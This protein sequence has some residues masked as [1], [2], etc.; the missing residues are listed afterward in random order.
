MVQSQGVQQRRMQVVR[1]NLVFDRLDAKLV[2]LPVPQA[3]FHASSSEPHGIGSAV[4]VATILL[5]DVRRSSEFAAPHH[6]CVFQHVAA[7]QVC[8]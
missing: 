5:L 7:L 8:Q 1:V 3:T 2:A 4:V 6:Q